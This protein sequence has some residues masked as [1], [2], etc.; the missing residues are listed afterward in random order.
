M[1]E[2]KRIFS[3]I[4]NMFLCGLVVSKTHLPTLILTCLWTSGRVLTKA[5]T[6]C[7]RLCFYFLYSRGGRDTEKRWWGCSDQIGT[8]P[9]ERKIVQWSMH[10]RGMSILAAGVLVNRALMAHTHCTGFE[11]TQ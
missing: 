8:I 5:L 2:E 4:F 6:L 9:M 1:C 11:R 3:K 7:K 10:G